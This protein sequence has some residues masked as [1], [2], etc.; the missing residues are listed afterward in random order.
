M[1]ALFIGQSYID[2]TFL[3]DEMPTG[4]DKSVARDYA[5]SFGG[6][7]VTAAFCCAKLG[8]APDLLASVADDWLGRMFIDM[9]AKYGI[10]VHHRK[11]KESSLSFIMPKGGQ[12]AIVRCRDD[13]YLHPFPPLNL[14]GCRGAACRRP[15]GGRRDPLRQGVPRGRHADL[16]RRRR[17]RSNT[18]EL[19]AFIDVAVVAERLCE[20]MKLSPGEMLH[21]LRA[22][23]CQIGGVTMGEHGLVWYDEAGDERVLPAL[24]GAR[25][26]R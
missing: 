21:Y 10:S 15:S 1:K 26:R 4:D 23:G 3:A 5:I 25:R 24:D 12:R 11:V 8:I 7:A 22:R 14:A 13:H 6:N 20:Q 16:A 19:L 17:L 18:H 2:V 9:A